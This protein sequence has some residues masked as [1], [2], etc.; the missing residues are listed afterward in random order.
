[1]SAPH[2]PAQVK[3]Q[4][5]KVMEG[6]SKRLKSE[7]HRLRFYGTMLVV[8]EHLAGLY[9]R[10]APGILWLPGGMEATCRTR[11]FSRA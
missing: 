5:E 11:P 2:A 4:R 1:V 6:V 3:E 7:M 10:R 8:C 9:R